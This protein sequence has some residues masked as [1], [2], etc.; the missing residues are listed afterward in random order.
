MSA[1]YNENLQNTTKIVCSPL[2]PSAPTPP[3][4][5]ETFCSVNSLERILFHWNEIH[6]HCFQRC[7]FGMVMLTT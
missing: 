6:P 2:S 1:S 5:L 3:K 4:M 7:S